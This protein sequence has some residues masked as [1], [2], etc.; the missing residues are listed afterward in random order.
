MLN[1]IF[2]G[3]PG[4]GKGTQAANVA[5]HF[6]LVH[7]STGEILRE[8]IKQN[9]ELGLKVKD[10]M[11]SGEL[12]PDELLIEILENSCANYP[13]A[14]GFVFDGFPRTLRQAEALDE[15]MERKKCRVALVISLVVPEEELLRRL[16]NRARELGRT[17]DTE[18]VIRNRLIVYQKHTE[19]LIEYYRKRGIFREVPGV[20]TVQDIFSNLCQV[21]DKYK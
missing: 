13:G 5:R 14:K 3:P 10:V 21:I 12:V 15:M 1:L 9:T 19:P 8:E 16:L 18:D 17:D 6:N 11:A 7:I 2:F 4:V 20:G